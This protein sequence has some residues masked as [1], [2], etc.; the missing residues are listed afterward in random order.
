MKNDFNTICLTAYLLIVSL[1]ACSNKQEKNNDALIALGL[2]AVDAA[3][4]QCETNVA[5]DSNFSK[6]TPIE[7]CRPSAGEARHFRFENVGMTSN[8]GYLNLLIGYGTPTPS[9]NS[10]F[11][12]QAAGFGG[13]LSPT[14]VSG[15]GR[16]RIFMGTSSSCNRSWIVSRFSGINGNTNLT[17]QDLFTTT[18]I[19]TPTFSAG[20]CPGGANQ[21]TGIHGPSTICMDVSKGAEGVSPRITIWASGINKANCNDLSTLTADSKIYEK[22]DWTSLVATRTDRNF[23]YRDNDGA[24]LTKVILRS[25]TVLKD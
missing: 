23:I 6:E 8:N 25:E 10:E 16:W 13:A 2:V 14:T 22:K 15:D 12:P 4:K 9:A 17:T 18:A 5:S 3:S 1:I 19:A 24:S 21:A 7:L 11:W 20:T